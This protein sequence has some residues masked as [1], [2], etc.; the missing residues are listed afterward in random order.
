MSG[1]GEKLDRLLLAPLAPVADN[2][3]S[4]RVITQVAGTGADQPWLEA[5]VLAAAA[6]ILFAAVPL[7]GLSEWLERASA[8]LAAT[9][10]PLA[11]AG[12]ALA[13]TWSYTRALAD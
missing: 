13:I 3:F 8:N 9:A 7:G 11:I 4:E 10:L 6:C 5:A 1:D 2:G 12:F